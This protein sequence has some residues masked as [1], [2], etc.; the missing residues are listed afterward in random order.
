MKQVLITD[1]VHPHLIEGLRERGFQCDYQPAIS[2]EET[3]QKIGFYQGLIINSKIKADR[4][5]LNQAREL[6]F[7]GR[8]GSGLEIIDLD[9]AREFGIQVL[10]APEGNCN[11]VAEHALGM[12]LSLLNHL[13]RA[14]REVR[15]F[16]WNRE[17][18]RGKEL[19][20]LSVGII[21]YGHTGPAFAEK[22][23]GLGVTVIAY[24]RFNQIERPLP[25]VEVGDL[26]DIQLR[27]DVISL[28]VSLNPSSLHMID[29]HFIE[30]CRKPF[31][32]INTARGQAVKTSDLIWGLDQGKITGACLDV[33]ENEKPLTFSEVEK[34]L[35]SQ[36]YAM[37]Q[38]I[39]SPHIAGWTS[40]SKLRIAEVLL[41]KLDT[42]KNKL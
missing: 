42:H 9:A 12:L 31:I 41:E 30:N 39:L 23:S 25:H 11:A 24:D 14:D 6:Q 32:L 28:H 4:L 3:R 26:K 34:D 5:F 7:I 40:E 15:Q 36:L 29:R 16:T 21:G 1:D 27:A 35:Y 8:L 18:N 17:K 33:F 37:E 13:N 38:V 19:K 2:L 20:G 22:L 10:S